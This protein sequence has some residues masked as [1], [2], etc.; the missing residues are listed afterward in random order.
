MWTIWFMC[1]RVVLS[2]RH[3]VR[4]V[5]VSVLFGTELRIEDVSR[6]LGV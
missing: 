4:F 2:K 6:S 3:F 5:V 1:D